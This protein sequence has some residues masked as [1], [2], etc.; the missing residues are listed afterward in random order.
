MSN[1]IPLD[2]E[3]LTVQF[4]REAW[5]CATTAAARF[6]KQP[7]EWLRLPD[8]KEYLT[9]LESTYGKIPYVKTSRAR[10]ADARSHRR[11]QL[12]LGLLRQPAF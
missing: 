10:V 2:Y 11:P 5:F 6:G 9:A 12:F 7:K 3:G 4:T 8:T 1:I